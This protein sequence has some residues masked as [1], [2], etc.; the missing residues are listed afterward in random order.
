MDYP[1]SLAVEDF[2][3]VVFTTCGVLLLRRVTGTPGTIAAAALIGAGGFAKATAK[4]VVAL[5]GPDLVWLR[6]ALFPLLTL[7]FALLYLELTRNPGISR[8]RAAIAAAVTGVCAVAALLVAD[9]LPML[10]STTVF[11][12][13]TAVR[14]IGLARSRGDTLAAVL[15]GAQIAVFFVLGPLGARADQTVA[16]QWIEQLT[17]TAGQAAFLLGAVR[18]ARTNQGERMP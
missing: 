11:A 5:D 4:L 15:F 16:L 13:L 1:V 17:N 3:P 2:V 8:T 12:T 7:G 10:V 18:L 14:L 9:A 6:S